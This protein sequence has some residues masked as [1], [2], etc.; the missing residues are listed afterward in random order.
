MYIQMYSVY[1]TYILQ[2]SKAVHQL[3]Y[4]Y[5]SQASEIEEAKALYRKEAHQRRL[6]FNEV[7]NYVLTNHIVIVCLLE[8]STKDILIISILYISI[9]SDSGAERKYSSIL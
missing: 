5:R 7:D 6:L 2:L 8:T 9:F 3:L 1:C 4:N